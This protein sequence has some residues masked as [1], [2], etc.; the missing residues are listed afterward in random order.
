MKRASRVLFFVAAL[1][2]SACATA[3][4]QAPS[5]AAP[6]NYVLDPA[7]ASVIWSLSHAGLSQYTARFDDISGTLNFNPD[8]PETSTVD[9]SIASDSVSTGLPKFDETLRSE[10]KY[11]N[12]PAYPQ[13]RF[14]STFAQKLTDTTGTVTGDLSFRGVTRPVTL[15]TTFNGA[16]KSFGHPGDTLGFSATGIIKRSDFGMDTLLNF[17]IGDAV[18]LR[19]EAEFNQAQ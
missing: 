5:A 2:L 16:G 14:M 11:F 7:H 17:G 10:A 1:S 4:V 15:Q 13:I 6:G 19:I 3:P 8:A 18:K 9:I 12:A